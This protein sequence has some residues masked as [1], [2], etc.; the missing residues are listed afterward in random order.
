MKSIK[1][2]SWIAVVLFV[3]DWAWGVAQVRGLVPLWSFLCFNF[4][5]GLPYV[6]LEAHWARTHY[7][8]GGRT[9]SEWWSL[10]SFFFMILAQA[11]LY[12]WLWRFYRRRH[13]TN[14]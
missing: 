10:G 13:Q 8:V 9:V 7:L 5:F 4:P 6:W 11:A 14:S 12:S 1:A 3:F 2:Y